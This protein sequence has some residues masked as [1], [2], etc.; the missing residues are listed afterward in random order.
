M[1]KARGWDDGQK[2]RQNISETEK[3]ALKHC[4]YKTWWCLAQLRQ[5]RKVCRCDRYQRS[6]RSRRHVQKGTYA[7]EGTTAELSKNYSKVCIISMYGIVKGKTYAIHITKHGCICDVTGRTFGLEAI[8]KFATQVGSQMYVYDQCLANKL[9]IGW[10]CTIICYVNDL[11]SHIWKFF[12]GK[13][14]KKLKIK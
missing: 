9:I 3:Q 14:N 12:Y 6:L 11:K 2:Q 1:I 7:L 13:H 5:K 10:Q 8:V 4:P